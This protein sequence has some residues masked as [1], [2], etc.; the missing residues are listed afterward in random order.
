[1]RHL[2]L[3]AC[4]SVGCSGSSPGGGGGGGGGGGD[5]DMQGT[6][7]AGGGGGVVERACPMPASTANPGALTA[8]K[9]EMCNV[10]GSMGAAHWYK[11]AAA[12]P[13][14]MNYVQVELWDKTGA[15]AGGLV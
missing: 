3:I 12:L 5:D 11:L 8:S 13:G 6:P 7:D 2:L 4:V 10:S 1:M 14:T 15:F 9:A